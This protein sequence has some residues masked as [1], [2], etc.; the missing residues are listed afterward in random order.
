VS[1]GEAMQELEGAGSLA[2]GLPLSALLGRVARI[3]RRRWRLT[4]AT[5]FIAGIAA[6][7]GLQA[8]HPP[9]RPPAAAVAVGR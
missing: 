5:A 1:A 7:T 8:L 2:P 3:R 6:A 9:A 4:A